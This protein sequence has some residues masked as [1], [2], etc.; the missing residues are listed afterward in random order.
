[1]DGWMD[2]RGAGGLKE[3]VRNRTGIGGRDKRE[4]AAVGVGERRMQK[5]DCGYYEVVDVHR[6]SSVIQFNQSRS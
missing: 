4:G 1:M 3:F 5:F 6:A 2:G